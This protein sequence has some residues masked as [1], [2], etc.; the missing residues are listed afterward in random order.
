MADAAEA[1]A[2]SLGAQCVYLLAT[3]FYS[4]SIFRGLGYETEHTTPY[5]K[6]VPDDNERANIKDPRHTSAAT[7]YKILETR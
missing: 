6:V 4:G 5:N 7:L 3:G 1:Y 2:K